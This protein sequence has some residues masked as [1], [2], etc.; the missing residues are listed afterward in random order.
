MSSA[1][2][3]SRAAS[4]AP[5]PYIA[6]ALGAAF[7]CYAF[8]QRVSPSIMV[9]DLMREFAVSAAVLG[10]LSAFYLYAYA[11]LQIPVGV[12]MDRLGPRR[13]MT[14][15]AL[16]SAAGALLFATSGSIGGGYVG[17]ALIGAGC[18]FS[19]VG[20]LTIATQWLPPARFAL[21]A[22]L[23]QMLGMA[24]GVF[25]QAPLALAVEA[26]G[27]RATLGAIGAA[28]L[29]LAAG[30][31]FGVRDRPHAENRAVGV[32]GS[33]GVVLRTR[34]TWIA[35]AFG[36]AMTGPMLA[37]GALW[38][39]P[40]LQ[41]AYGLERA[42]AAGLASLIFV[43]WALAAPLIGFLADR[44]RRLK[45]QMIAFGSLAVLT[46]VLLLYVPG[47]PLA[48]VAA[49]IALHGAAASCMHLCF[50]VAKD[51]VPPGMSSSAMGV[52][53]MAVVGSGALFQ[54]LIGILLDLNWDGAM[55]AGVRVYAPEAYRAAFV[56][57]PV[58]GAMGVA[59]VLAIR[60][61]DC[62]HA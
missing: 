46:L 60:R 26:M 5:H 2:A 59:A 58:A 50:V 13:L 8:F 31:W 11:G 4:A 9:E 24:G 32:G 43:G 47:L 33:L 28:G 48:A 14:V 12:L 23:A 22:G 57:L 25:G 35:A 15:A 53:N 62:G 29:V 61:R 20:V 51:H 30:I 54:P 16:A 40:Y 37:F 17:R 45:A 7:F 6:W 38:A 56:V 41:A 52:V 27:W 39:V 49:L 10:N 36:L 42:S 19:W 1:P 18:A 3:A 44:M 21:L 34:E 55:L